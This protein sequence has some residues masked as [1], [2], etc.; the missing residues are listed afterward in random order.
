MIQARD[1][2]PSGDRDSESYSRKC[3]RETAWRKNRQGP[4]GL[5]GSQGP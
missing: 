5:S 3:L 2:V 4:A 1:D